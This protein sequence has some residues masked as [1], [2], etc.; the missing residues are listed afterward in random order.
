MSNPTPLVKKT[1]DICC[2]NRSTFIKCPYCPFESCSDCSQKY[3]LDNIVSKCM[4]CSKQWSY[5]FIQNNFS[6]SFVNTK[7]KK[8]RE[9]IL[10]SKEKSLLPNTQIIFEKKKKEK[11]LQAELEKLRER[12][13]F[14]KMKLHRLQR[15]STSDIYVRRKNKIHNCIQKDCRGF[16]AENNT[17]TMT[18]GVCSIKVCKSCREPTGDEHKCDPNIVENLKAIEKECKP[19][20]K[21]SSMIYFISGCS[22]MWCTQCQT[23]FNW[24]TGKIETGI[25]HNPHYWEYVKKLGQEDAEVNRMFGNGQAQQQNEIDLCNFRFEDLLR[26]KTFASNIQHINADILDLF[27]Q[28]NHTSRF[29]RDKYNV[30]LEDPKLNEDIRIKYLAKEINED[31]MKSLIQ[32]RYKMNEFKNEMFQIIDTFVTVS[33]TLAVKYYHLIIKEGGHQK[34]IVSWMNEISELTK[35]SLDSV[36]K[37]AKR[38]SYKVPFSIE[39]TLETFLS[40][41]ERVKD[42]VEKGNHE[43]GLRIYLIHMFNTYSSK[44]RYTPYNVAKREIEKLWAQLSEEQRLYYVSR[45]K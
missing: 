41:T 33:R 20:P 32:R 4:S 28:I 6:V 5:E 19:C 36:I 11:E 22:Q 12:E 29:E 18:C 45:D 1:C 37:L 39:S 24:K 43:K 23:A 38:F 21:C 35:F 14:L 15:Q 16:L 25:I 27:R 30:N 10:L 3:L 17:P 40:I 34:V 42:F 2:S 44:Y 9:D 26:N 31:Y 13:E 8:H 7:Y